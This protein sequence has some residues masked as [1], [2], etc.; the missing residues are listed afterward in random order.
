MTTYVLSEQNA[1][2][3]V[4][5]FAEEADVNSIASG[6]PDE[7]E[8]MQIVLK[9]ARDDQPSQILRIT[10]NGDSRLIV[11]FNDRTPKE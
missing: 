7:E 1:R 11:Q 10:A 9:K 4:Y 5:S 3:N 2:W 8:A 6:I